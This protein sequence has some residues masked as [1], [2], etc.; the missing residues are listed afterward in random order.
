MQ[1]DNNK[2]DKEIM[3]ITHQREQLINNLEKKEAKIV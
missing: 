2:K 3:T 1:I